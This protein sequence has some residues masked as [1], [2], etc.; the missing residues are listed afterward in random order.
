M[1]FSSKIVEEAV[2][3]IAE[4]PGIGRKSALRLV[5]FLL[6]NQYDLAGELSESILKLKE[7]RFCKSCHNLA[8]SETCNICSAVKRDREIICVVES[9][10]DIMAI[11]ETG[12][13]NGLY[14]VLGGVISPLDGIGPADLN[15]DSLI[16]RVQQEDV[17]E[18]IMAI[19]PTIDGETTIY[20]LSRVLPP[21]RKI[22]TIAR[23]VSFGGELE[24]AD[25]LTLGRSISNRIPYGT[26]ENSNR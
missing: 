7:V 12:H 18:L 13:Y 24:Y 21:D 16:Q 15:I 9:V 25:E 4:L 14:H 5:L 26:R 10:R 20:Y 1:N 6:N 11:E 3:K 23:G 2:Q 22:T 19:S 8:D 17:R